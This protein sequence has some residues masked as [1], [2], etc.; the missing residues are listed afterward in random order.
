MN[1]AAGRIALARSSS[2][3]LEVELAK[4]VQTVERGSEEH[5]RFVNLG[6]RLDGGALSLSIRG[7]GPR[8]WGADTWPKGTALRILVPEN[9]R[10]EIVSD[11]DLTVCR[12]F[13]AVL[14]LRGDGRGPSS[15]AAGV[16][17]IAEK[18]PDR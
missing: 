14:V 9:V 10:L 2:D 15:H 16:A 3:E 5:R 13:P 1:S 4:V 11:N 6:I 7:S 12:D 17:Q 18:I 8:M